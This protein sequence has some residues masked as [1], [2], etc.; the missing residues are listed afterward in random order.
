MSMLKILR[1]I[2]T[3]TLGLVVQALFLSA[4]TYAYNTDIKTNVPGVL[5]VIFY[6][7]FTPISYGV[8]GEGYEGDLLRAVANLWNMKIKFHKESTYEGLWLLP[9]NSYTIADLSMGGMTPS[10]YRI[11]Q[12]AL[13]S[14]GTTAFDQ[15]LLIRKKDYKSGLIV[16]YQS[17]K[18]NNLKIGVVPGTT[19]ELYAHLRAKEN[20]VPSDIFVQYAS[21]SELLPALLHGKIDAIARGEIGNQYQ[22]AKNK[23]LIVIAKKSFGENFAFAIDSS[24]KILAHNLNQAIRQITNNGKI[25]YLQWDRKHTIFMDRVYQLKQNLE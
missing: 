19:G 11:K 14:I 25:T 21:E 5:N 3:V 6:S 9:S 1:F 12:G 18:K 15:S 23:N 13:F 20:N 2:K 22:A 10:N 17:F 7:K 24:N 16:S 4:V 8:N